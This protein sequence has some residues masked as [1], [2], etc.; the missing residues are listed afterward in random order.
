M[1]ANSPSREPLEFGGSQWA[2]RDRTVGTSTIHN[3]RETFVLVFKRSA[4]DARVRIRGGQTR[5]SGTARQTANGQRSGSRELRPLSCW[6]YYLSS[7]RQRSRS[8]SCPAPFAG[9]CA[10]APASCATRFLDCARCKTR[11]RE[12]ELSCLGR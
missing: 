3:V 2:M 6:F 8:Q 12:S 1:L 4:L 11:R 9:D 5:R 10:P 7:P